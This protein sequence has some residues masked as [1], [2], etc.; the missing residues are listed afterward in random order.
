MEEIF[1]VIAFHYKFLFEVE[2]ENTNNDDDGAWEYDDSDMQGDQRNEDGGAQFQQHRNVLLLSGLEVKNDCREQSHYEIN[3]I[4]SLG[5][6]HEVDLLEGRKQEFGVQSIHFHPEYALL[7]IKLDLVA[8]QVSPTHAS[9]LGLDIKRPLNL[10][11]TFNMQSI[12]YA[13]DFA[14]MTFL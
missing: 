2:E 11:M 10:E 13:S 12:F 4:K 3:K 14:E 1:D 5:L 9:F 8:L 7:M 6:A